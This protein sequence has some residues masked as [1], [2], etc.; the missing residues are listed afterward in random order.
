MIGDE[1]SRDRVEVSLALRSRGKEACDLRE[2]TVIRIKSQVA[3]IICQLSTAI[4]IDIEAG[5]K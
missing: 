3:T 5:C 4:I 2:Q 1:R